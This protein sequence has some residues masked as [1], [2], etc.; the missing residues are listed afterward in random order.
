MIV[1]SV[2]NKFND[3]FIDTACKLAVS[4]HPQ[5][6]LLQ[7]GGICR[8]GPTNRKYVRSIPN[9]CN[10]TRQFQADMCTYVCYMCACTRSACCINFPSL[11]W[12]ILSIEHFQRLRCCLKVLKPDSKFKNCRACECQSFVYLSFSHTNFLIGI[13]HACKWVK[14][15]ERCAV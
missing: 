5:L 8:F 11:F 13:L 10:P 7:P 1:A 2:G 3:I 15:T 12:E 14:Y 6:L 4:Y 9:T